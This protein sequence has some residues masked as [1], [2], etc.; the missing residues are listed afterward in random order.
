MDPRLF[1]RL[2]KRRFG[3]RRLM[4]GRLTGVH[5]SPHRG[6]SIEFAEHKEY[7]PGDEIRHIDWKAVGKSDKYYVKQFEKETNLRCYLVLDGSG[8]MAYRSEG[9]SKWDYACFLSSALA[10]LLLQQSDAVGVIIG[11]RGAPIYVPPRASASHIYNICR[12]LEQRAP[13]GQVGLFPALDL[14]FEVASRRSQAVILS[15]FFDSSDDLQQHLRRLKGRRMQI[16]VFHVLD[17]AELA[18]PFQRLTLFKAMEGSSKILAE[19]RLVRDVYLKALARFRGDLERT[20]RENDV[21][22]QLMSTELTLE[23]SV[24]RFLGRVQ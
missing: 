3:T 1:A 6:A 18:F 8:S 17:P 15:D 14:L 5:H 22:Y 2:G 16:S 12:A 20:C 13:T 7:S 11:G 23:E 24:T 4:D 9:M 21:D 10:H 19:P